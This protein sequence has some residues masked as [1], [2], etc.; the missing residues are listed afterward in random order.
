MFIHGGFEHE[1]PNIPL[2]EICKIDAMKL[3][4]NHA[5]LLSKIKPLE[6]NSKDERTKDGIKK[7]P[8]AYY[9]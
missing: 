1:T 5:N 6:K 4:T 9:N 3:L 2:K 8:N 7:N